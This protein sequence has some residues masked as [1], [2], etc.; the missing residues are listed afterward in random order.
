MRAL[1]G[2][3]NFTVNYS[4]HGAQYAAHIV[5]ETATN[6]STYNESDILVPITSGMTGAQFLA[7]FMAAIDAEADRIGLPAPTDIFGNQ[8]TKFR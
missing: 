6:P 4:T 2:E 8:I 3:A 5:Y 1:I 7:A